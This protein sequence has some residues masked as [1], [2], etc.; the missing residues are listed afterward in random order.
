MNNLNLPQYDFRIR[1]TGQK[2]EIFDRIRKKWVALTPEEWVRQNFLMYL[3][4]EKNYPESLMAVEA[5]F[6]LYKRKKRSDIVVYNNLG[7][8]VLIVECKAPEVK[9]NQ[10]VFDQVAR[11]NMALKVSYL[12][13]TN[14][15]D[16]YCCHLDYKKNSYH[17]L[18]KVPEYSFILKN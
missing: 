18:K 3:I 10:G 13:V 6:K 9:I 1:E 8:P 11:Y 15:L 17:F 7:E 12:I 4:S 16:H 2:K 5:G 14:G